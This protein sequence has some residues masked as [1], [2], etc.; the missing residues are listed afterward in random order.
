MVT[1]VSITPGTATEVVTLAKAKKYLRIESSFTDEDDL[2]QDYIDSAVVMA[3]NYIGGHIADKNM[4]IK[5]TGFDNPLV[6][7]VFPVKTVTSIK[8]YEAGVEEE[9]T[10][11]VSEYVL[12]SETQKR[13]AIRYKNTLPSVQDRF[14]AVTVT[15]NIGMETIEKPIAQAVMLMVAD[16]YERREDRPEVLSTASMSLLRPYKKF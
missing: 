10:L 2:I 5:S 8:Y 7:E 3:E 6:F 12:N 11:D 4:V 15:I 1:D 14:D 9:K 13:F 16:M